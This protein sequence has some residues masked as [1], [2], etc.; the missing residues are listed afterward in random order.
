MYA[1]GIDPFEFQNYWARFIGT[2]VKNEVANLAVDPGIDQQQS[3]GMFQRNN[4]GIG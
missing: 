4:D 3:S 2:S 1:T